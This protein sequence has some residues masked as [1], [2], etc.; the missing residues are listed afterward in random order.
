MSAKS[1]GQSVAKGSAILLIANL[2]VKIIGALFKIPLQRLIGNEGM[3]YFG[4]AYSIYS[5]LFVV[6]T[7]GL[8][9]AVSKMVSESMVQGNLRET[10][11]IYRTAYAIFLAIGII[12]S[13][14]LFLFADNWAAT[15]KFANSNIA[16]RAIAPSILF[17]SL[18]SVYRGFFQ[19]MSNMIPTA[20]SE[21]VEASGKLIIGYILA[22]I[23][24]N[25]GL[26]IAASGAVLGVTAGSLMSLIILMLIHA[27]KKKAIY[28]NIDN[29]KAPA[30]TGTILKKL[31]MIA[32]PVTISASV[33]T[34]TNV[35][36]TLLIG[37][38]LSSIEHLLSQTKDSL[39]G[40]YTGQA[41]VLYNMPPTLVMSLCLAL[42]PAIARAF[43]SGDTKTVRI[44]TTQSLK[45]AYIFALPCAVGLGTLAK[46]ILSI[47]FEG[48]LAVTALQLLAPAV[49]FVSMVLVT[50]SIL[51][52]TGNVLVPVANIFVGGLAKVIINNILVSN[53]AININ[54]APVGT[55]VCYFIYMFLNL[56]YIKKI[57]KADIGISFWV[58]PLLAAV[59]MGV[60]AYFAYG[61]LSGVLVGGTIM[62]I[63]NFVIAGGCS[64]VAYLLTLL[65]FG[66]VSKEDI[67][68]FPK[69]E[70]I[71]AILAKFKLLRG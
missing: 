67:L 32:I 56:I 4:A 1:M 12:G 45:T 57:T 34:L 24:L 23:L 58:R 3:G 2:M 9:V 11:R 50:N 53:P 70:K 63:V 15:T 59:V 54:G 37:R 41:V 44:T 39:Y 30:P 26:H 16:I 28:E 71:A 55:T 36:D 60:V 7:A 47:L 29:T 40:M 17:V 61:I 25:R 49:V 62:T 51:Q 21:V 6:A 20:I 35:I 68:T 13:G 66:G 52:A 33:F 42:V 27:K 22:Y 14:A 5:G 48:E 38:N 64:V 43:V 10:K 31:L 8:P 65:T 19:G 69:G 46:P 18:M